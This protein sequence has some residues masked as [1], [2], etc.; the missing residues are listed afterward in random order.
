M[1]ISDQIHWLP[2]AKRQTKGYSIFVGGKA[3]NRATLSRPLAD[4]L[5]GMSIQWATGDNGKIV[6]RIAVPGREGT[7]IASY[8][9]SGP[10]V[11]DGPLRRLGVPENHRLHFD[12]DTQSA[13]FI[14]TKRQSCKV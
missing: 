12:F 14:E 2:R 3:T 4:A 9:I 7:D 11:F 10:Q 6:F 1:A 13:L 5:Q 8:R